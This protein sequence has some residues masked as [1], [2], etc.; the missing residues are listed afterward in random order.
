MP[1]RSLLTWRTTATAALNEMEAAHA[2]VGGTGRGRRYAIQQINQ[3][4]TVLLSS[5]FQRFCRDLHSEA[6]DH[7]ASVIAPQLLSDIFRSRLMGEPQ[8]GRWQSK[9]GKHWK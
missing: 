7:L 1:S 8:I 5:R 3:A 6:V 2:A 4:Y 9:S